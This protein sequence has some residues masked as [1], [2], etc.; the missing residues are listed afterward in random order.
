MFAVIGVNP[1][2]K[3]TLTDTLRE[4]YKLINHEFLKR[5]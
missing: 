2:V 4:K 5:P 1:Y 3:I